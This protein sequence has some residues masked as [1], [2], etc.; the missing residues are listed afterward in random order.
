M[1]IYRQKK[2]PIEGL[3]IIGIL[4]GFIVSEKASAQVP[5]GSQELKSVNELLS[6]CRANIAR[7]PT[8]G[9]RFCRQALLQISVDPFQ[10]QYRK[11]KIEAF[12]LLGESYLYTGRIEDAEIHCDSTAALTGANETDPLYR[13]AK[14]VQ[15]QIERYF[16]PLSIKIKNREIPLLSY[17]EGI[18]IEFRYPRRLESFQ[19]KRLQI[20]QDARARRE[21]EFQFVGIDADGHAYMEIKYFP[22]ITYSG[23]SVGFALI[24]DGRRRYRF[25]FT[26]ENNE[27]LEIFW[28]EESQ[29][30]LIER[31]PDSMVKIELPGKYRFIPRNLPPSAPY[32]ST[33]LDGRQHVYIPSETEVEMTLL[34]SED[35]KWERI[36]QFALYGTTGLAVL[37]GLFGAR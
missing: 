26:P 9:Q 11:E 19:I 6:D 7:N 35:S 16:R 21:G 33:K 17:I 37:V 18:D 5:V 15:D 32:M 23:R 25:N 4:M 3:L 30:R 27:T 36:Y 24:I 22:L 14:Q 10:E 13:R 1:R 8:D 29:W 34:Q 20:L 2:R 28:D 31:I 12:T